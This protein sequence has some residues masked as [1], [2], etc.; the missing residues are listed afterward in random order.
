MADYRLSLRVIRTLKEIDETIYTKSSIMLGLG[1]TD[2]EVLATMAELRANGCDIVFL[3][4]YLSPDSGQLAV[5]EY[6]HPDKFE[7]YRSE[8]LRMG[9]RYVASSP[10]VRSSY[11]A[12]E[13]L[14]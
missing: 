7:Y 10:Y 12:E 13:A 9:F 4:Q 14:L 11:L 3:G 2:H 6:I 8:A 1:E 5:Q